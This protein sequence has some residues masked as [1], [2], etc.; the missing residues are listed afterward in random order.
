VRLLTG[1][2]SR[3]LA[4]S[5]RHPRWGERSVAWLFQRAAEHEAEH[6]A[7]LEALRARPAAQTS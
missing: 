3:Q 6:A 1:L 7:Q 4:R 2:S 5:V